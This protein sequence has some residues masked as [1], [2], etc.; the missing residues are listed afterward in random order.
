VSP[1][2]ASGLAALAEGRR[3][4]SEGGGGGGLPPARVFDPWSRIAGGRCRSLPLLER[5][6][7]QVGVTSRLPCALPTWESPVRAQSL[8][9]ETSN[10]LGQSALGARGGSSLRGRAYRAAGRARCSLA[11][12]GA[13]SREAPGV[14][15]RHYLG[16]RRFADLKVAR[17]S[18][19]GR[20][21]NRR[22]G[23]WLATRFHRP[24]CG[25]G[26]SGGTRR[27]EQ[28]DPQGLPL[29]PAPWARGTRLRQPSGRSGTRSPLRCCGSAAATRS[30]TERRPLRRARFATAGASMDGVCEIS[31]PA[32]PSCHHQNTRWPGRSE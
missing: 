24:F 19:A 12:L 7:M 15:T 20:A 3:S 26:H 9:P 10:A 11:P 17:S 31:D 21:R 16:L 5:Q 6:E 30:P 32:G 1:L 23:W 27:D 28:A 14:S 8:A 18:R 22:N 25:W 2:L 29:A 13:A 4:A